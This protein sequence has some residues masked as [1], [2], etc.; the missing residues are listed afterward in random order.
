[1]ILPPDGCDALMAT[2]WSSYSTLEVAVE[3]KISK[4]LKPAGFFFS[5]GIKVC[6]NWRPGGTNQRWVF[7]RFFPRRSGLVAEAAI[8][9]EVLS[10]LPFV[11]ACC[12][13]KCL[14]STQEKASTRTLIVP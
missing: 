3:S 13:C 14:A 12:R 10:Y 5:P 8:K 2:W 1:M 4:L 7:R 11:V 9:A 6:T